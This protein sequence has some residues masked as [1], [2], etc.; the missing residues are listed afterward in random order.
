MGGFSL[1]YESTCCMAWGDI[2]G[3]RKYRGVVCVFSIFNAGGSVCGCMC[4]YTH[5]HT[6]TA[7]M[8]YSGV[9]SEVGMRQL[10]SQKNPDPLKHDRIGVQ[11]TFVYIYMLGCGF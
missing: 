8:G 4:V 2:F 9:S 11:S 7:Q 1:V 3:R 6:H 10:E 5:T